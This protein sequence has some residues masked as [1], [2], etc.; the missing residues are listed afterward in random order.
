MLNLLRKKLQPCC[1]LDHGMMNESG[2]EEH[3]GLAGSWIN[4]HNVA[5]SC[6]YCSPNVIMTIK[7]KGKMGVV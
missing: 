7:K 6:L 3:L 5:L 4:L 1:K 2:G